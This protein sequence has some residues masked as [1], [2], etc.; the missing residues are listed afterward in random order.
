MSRRS[1]LTGLLVADQWETNGTVTGCAL[2]TDDEEK[3]IVR[4]DDR[5]NDILLLLRQQITINGTLHNE[6]KDK[7]LHVITYVPAGPGA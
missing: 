5:L 1:T 4:F 3:Y 6:N 7:I 2:L